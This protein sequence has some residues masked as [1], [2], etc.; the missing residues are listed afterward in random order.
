MKLARLTL[1]LFS[2]L[3]FTGCSQAQ[4][5]S[6][7]DLDFEE[8][9]KNFNKELIDHF[10][11]KM[12]YSDHSDYTC[13]TNKKKNNVGLLL[14]QYGVSLER[15]K[16]IEDNAKSKAISA[17]NSSDSCL[18]IV[19]RFETRETLE[20][21]D[22]PEVLSK[23][24]LNRSCYEGKFPLPN[25]VD[26]ENYNINTETKLDNGFDL[27]VIEA[28]S[29]YNFGYSELESNSQMPEKWKNGYT[30]GVAINKKKNTVIYWGIIW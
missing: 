23:H 10:P 21:N 27:Y 5:G 17:Y 6:N 1:M 12:D 19:N 2:M 22:I 8:C 3:F 26:Y 4:N 15:I 14:Y 13:K 11:E 25:F 24:L 18:L 9:K 30:K 28:K 20:N 7:F 29:N 16:L